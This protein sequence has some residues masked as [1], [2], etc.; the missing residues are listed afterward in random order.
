[1]IST[2]VCYKYLLVFALFSCCTLR[3]QTTITES[4]VSATMRFLTDDKLK[5]RDSGSEGILQAANFLEK[6]LQAAN[7]K[8]FYKSFK[9]TLSNFEKTAFNV[10]GWVEGNDPVLKNEFIIIGAHYDHI[11]IAEN[12]VKNDSIVNGANDNASGTT[13]VLMLAKYFGIEKANRRSLIFVFFSAEEKGLLGSRHL[14]KK[15]KNQKLNVYTM[16]NFEMIGVPL[17][18]K[19]YTA[20]ITGYAKSNMVEKLNQYAGKKLIGFHNI[21]LKYRL[22]MASDNYPFYTEMNIPSQTVCTFDFDNYPYYHHP[23]DEFERMDNK[24]ITS[25]IQDMLPVVSGM[26]NAASKEIKLK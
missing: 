21:E 16:L 25:F 5:G 10:V 14:A 9:D 11:G 24:H 3:A 19:D 13:A 4:E 15:M 22:F 12:A 8:P 1:M 17:Q 23:S 26:A 7:V 2:T 6:E 18:N 20:Y